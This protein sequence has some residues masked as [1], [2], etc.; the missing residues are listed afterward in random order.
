MRRR[1]IGALFVLASAC[2]GTG[3]VDAPPNASMTG[4]WSL[5]SVSGVALPIVVST[6]PKVELVSDVFTM[7]AAGTFVEASS[8]RT[9]DAAGAVTTTA[10][11]DSGTYVVSGNN[12]TFHFASDGS[13]ASASASGDTFTATSGTSV[14]LYKR[15]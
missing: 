14:F 1:F 4:T 10:G 7:A 9:T 13:S 15:Q 2:A 11:T 3:I 5:Q 6:P 8:F 12:V